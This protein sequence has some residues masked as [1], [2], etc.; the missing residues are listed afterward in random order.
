MD[1]ISVVSL[2]GI[3]TSITTKLV[4]VS[5]DLEELITKVRAIDRT[6][7]QLAAQLKMFSVTVAQ[8]QQWL[9]NDATMSDLIKETM[10]SALIACNEVVTEIEDHVRRI[11]PPD[12]GR[13]GVADTIRALW[14]ERTVQDYIRM[15]TTQFQ[16][17][18]L[19]IQLLALYVWFHSVCAP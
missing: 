18:N 6:T 1:P 19:F 7:T 17:F 3:C 8:L 11:T 5:R 2:L 13:L 10:Q 9:A 15:V 14:N 12:G 4:S 16:A